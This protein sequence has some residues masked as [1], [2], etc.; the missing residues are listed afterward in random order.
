MCP[1]GVMVRRVA[2]VSPGRSTCAA[3]LPLQRSL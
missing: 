1:E 3:W 2:I